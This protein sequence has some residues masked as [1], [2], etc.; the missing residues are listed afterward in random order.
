MPHETTQRNPVTARLQIEQADATVAVDMRMDSAGAAMNAFQA[1]D[2]LS[3]LEESSA[4]LSKG[5]RVGFIHMALERDDAASLDIAPAPCGDISVVFSPKPRRG[6]SKL[7]PNRLA[8][9]EV[10]GIRASALPKFFAPFFS[11]D[12]VAFV[13]TLKEFDT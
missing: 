4:R 6:L 2:W 7:L 5:E 13:Q 11:R 8:I 12:D 1:F 10:V 3:A 9:G